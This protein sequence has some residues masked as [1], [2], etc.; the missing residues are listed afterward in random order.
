MSLR[1]T[2]ESLCWSPH[3][4]GLEM[5]LVEETESHVYLLHQTVEWIFNK[6]Y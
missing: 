1:T 6:P 5:G 4:D 2:Y 3:F